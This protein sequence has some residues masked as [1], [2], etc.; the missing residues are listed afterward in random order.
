MKTGWWLK[1]FLWAQRMRCNHVLVRLLRHATH[2][3]P[4]VAQQEE[5]DG[6]EATDDLCHPEGHFPAVVLG[7]GAEW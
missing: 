5:S 4:D 3:G 6:S 7:N 1:V 2:L